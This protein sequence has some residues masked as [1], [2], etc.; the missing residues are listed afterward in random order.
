MMIALN[1]LE[2]DLRTNYFSYVPI[3]AS[4]H[5]K[6]KP[7]DV[8]NFKLTRSLVAFYLKNF[9]NCPIEKI[10]QHIVDGFKDN[11]I[12]GLYYDQIEKT[13]HIIQAKWIKNGTSGIELGDIE[14]SISGIRRLFIPDLKNFNEEVNAL[15]NEV[16]EALLEPNVNIVFSIVTSTSQAISKEIEQTISEF[17]LE[18]N[19]VTA[20]LSWDYNN[21]KILHDVLRSGSIDTP[22][23]TDLL[24]LNWSDIKDPVK[25]IIGSINGI[26]IANLLEAKGKRIFAP[27]IRYFLGKTEVNSSIIDSTNNEPELFWYLNNGITAIATS[28]EKKPLGGS[29]R[30]NGIFHCKGFYIVNGAQTTGALLESKKRGND[31][32]K[33]I[34]GIRIIQVNTE[35]PDFGIQITRSTNTQN[36]VDSRDFVALDPIQ[37]KLHQELL[38]DGVVYAYKAGDIVNDIN[39]G[40]HFEEAAIS[41]ACSLDSIDLTVQGKR[42]VSKL[43]SQTDKPP[44]KLLF[45]SGV[46]G[47]EVFRNVKIM[48]L[49]EEWIK[50]ER[51]STVARDRLILA[52]GNRFILQLV[53]RDL[54]NKEV[55]D[56]VV[57]ECAESSFNA[58]KRIIDSDYST[59]QLAS[60]FKNGEKCRDIYSK[61]VS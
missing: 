49:V 31:L 9:T 3:R 1:Q 4:E 16:N 48:R 15:E 56:K 42:E 29:S 22:I 24:L 47:R 61:I 32:N 60:L 46:N 28:I 11:G 54:K 52:H 50:T 23:D 5:E 26:D 43:W 37:E 58:L 53:F 34:L 55:N 41:I 33:V 40:F 2:H 59:D 20:F 39:K 38:I 12:D 7:E 21:L 25:A 51:K 36:R 10:S 44:Y 19:S 6:Y 30:E 35:N 13:L 27:N 45:N 17:L 14:K 57:L 18:Q 8:E